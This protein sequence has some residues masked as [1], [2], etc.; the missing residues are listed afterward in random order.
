MNAGRV[1]VQ[2][3]RVWRT[4]M[5]RVL[6]LLCV[7]V[8]MTAAAAVARQSAGQQNA[9]PGAVPISEE[10]HHHLIVDN[11]HIAAYDVEV[12]PHDATLMHI[13]DKDYA[14]IVFGDSD[15]MNAVEGKPAANQH[16]PDLAVNFVRGGFAHVEADMGNTPFR[17]VTIVL[18]HPQ[19][20]EK[21]YFPSAVAALA[22]TTRSTNSEGGKDILETDELRI[23]VIKIGPNKSW[24]PGKS[25]HPRFV[26]RTYE[27]DE[28]GLAKERTAPGFPVGLLD[29]VDA[30]RTATWMV[31]NNSPRAIQLVW[32]EFKD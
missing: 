13:H 5:P 17:N 28:P 26:I 9:F 23:S 27:I 29:F 12:D 10:G 4:F 24:I 14:Y 6:L 21:T 8:A 2:Q 20:E 11:S 16:I 31:R 3:L 30:A 15:I 32:I 25:N 7:L 1:S 19:G 22:D 18:K